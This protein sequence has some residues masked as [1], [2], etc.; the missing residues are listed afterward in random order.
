VK[1]GI[2]AAIDYFGKAVLNG[3]AAE[4]AFRKTHV[5]LDNLKLS[6]AE[7]AGD[8]CLAAKIRKQL[9][10]SKGKLQLA[11]KHQK[12]K[13]GL[14]DELKKQAKKMKEGAKP[15]KDRTFKFDVPFGDMTGKYECPKLSIFGCGCGSLPG[16][17]TLD[18]PDCKAMKAILAAEKKWDQKKV[19][20]ENFYNKGLGEMIQMAAKTKESEAEGN[21]LEDGE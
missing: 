1:G 12:E 5:D 20:A 13:L 11:E 4:V 8:G 21:L 19:D 7:G 15:T 17:E 6:E 10:T 14:P 3:Y 9:Q 2:D 18:G 16:Y